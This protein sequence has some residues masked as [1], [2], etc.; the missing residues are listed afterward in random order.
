MQTRFTLRCIQSGEKC[1]FISLLAPYPF[2]K[3]KFMIE[4]LSS[5]VKV[6]LFI[7]INNN[8]PLPRCL[9]AM[10][11]LQLV[12]DPYWTFRAQSICNWMAVPCVKN[13]Y[14]RTDFDQ[15][16]ST[17]LRGAVFVR[18][19]VHSTDLPI[20]MYM[21]S[22]RIFAGTKRLHIFIPLECTITCIA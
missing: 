19:S 11:T 4:I 18:H 22:L 2:N 1:S 17:C 15:F 14:G 8:C 13:H 20:C 10:K 12:L 5:S 9:V 7:Y 3:Y 16:M 21:W 6:I